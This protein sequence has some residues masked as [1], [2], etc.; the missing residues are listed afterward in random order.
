MSLVENRKRQKSCNVMYQMSEEE[1]VQTAKE[2]LEKAGQDPD[3]LKMMTS[4]SD[5]HHS[6][7]W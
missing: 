1:L 4:L 7:I 6:T 2:I 5:Q 3:K